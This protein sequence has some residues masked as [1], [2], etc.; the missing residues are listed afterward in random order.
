MNDLSPSS[1]ISFSSVLG[2]GVA[3]RRFEKTKPIVS[4][5][6]AKDAKIGKAVSGIPAAGGGRRGSRGS[7]SIPAMSGSVNE[8]GFHVSK[9]L[10]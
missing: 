9:S 7:A 10:N 4:R 6:D 1:G 5:K 2:L 8:P 3:R